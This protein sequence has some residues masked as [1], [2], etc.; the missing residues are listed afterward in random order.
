MERTLGEGSV[1]GLKKTE[2]KESQIF[3]SEPLLFFDKDGKRVSLDYKMYQGFGLVLPTDAG[4][5]ACMP[6][7]TYLMEHDEEAYRL[8]IKIDEERIREQAVW[9]GI[10]PGMRVADLG[11]GPGA[12]TALLHG[13]AQPGGSAVGLDGSA[14]RLEYARRKFGGMGIEYRRADLNQLLDEP[15]HFDFIWVRFVLEY[16][17]AGAFAMVRNFAR[18]LKPG[19]TLCLIDLD[20]NP[21]NYYGCSDR[22]DR[23]FKKIMRE[24]EERFDFD[25]FVGRKLYSFLYDLGFQDIDVRV[26]NHRVVFG[27][28]QEIE[29]FNMMKKIEVVPKRMNFVFDEYPGGHDEFYREAEAFFS[30][31]R[32][33][34]YTPLILCRGVK[35]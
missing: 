8:E 29:V 33:F 18:A 28:I 13:M 34:A 6:E 32:R 14:E 25:P 19:G 30:D 7:N 2:G 17:L 35:T 9:A 22:L 26:E 23:T 10:K 16:S 31:P 24:L 27:G 15:E 1:A 11:C 12:I 4:G 3:F 21:L 20:H 5:T